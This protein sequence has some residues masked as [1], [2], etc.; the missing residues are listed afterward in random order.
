[1]LLAIWSRDWIGWW[2]LL[3]VAVVVVWLFVNPSAFPPVEPR[4]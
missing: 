2:C 1:M 4:G 3:P